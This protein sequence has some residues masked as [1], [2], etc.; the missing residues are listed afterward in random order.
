MASPRQGEGLVIS[1]AKFFYFF[2][3]LCSVL[4]LGAHY[5]IMAFSFPYSKQRPLFGDGPY[6]IFTSFMLCSF[7]ATAM[8]LFGFRGSE[9]ANGR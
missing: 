2:I 6:Q 1:M 4:L 7:L 5:L 3:I 8:K 9:A